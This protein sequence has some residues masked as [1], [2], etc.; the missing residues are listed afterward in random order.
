MTSNLEGRVFQHKSKQPSGFTKK[1][2]VTKLVY[3]EEHPTALEA[4]A[5]E[6]QLKSFSRAKKVALID[7]I[8]P[9]W[10]DL[11]EDWNAS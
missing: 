8:N 1:Y 6:K 3:Y 4:I 7:S 11:A 5:R 2:D 9:K 10:S